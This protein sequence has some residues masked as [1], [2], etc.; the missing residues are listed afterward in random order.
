MASV[1]KITFDKTGTLTY[2]TPEVTAVKS[3]LSVYSE[4]EEI[5]A[6]CASAEQLSEHPLGKAVAR[7]YTKETKKAAEVP[8]DFQM[9]PGQGVSCTADSKAILAGNAKMMEQNNIPIPKHVQ[10]SFISRNFMQ[11][12][13]RK[14]S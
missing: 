6:L 5:Y 1:T 7:C 13:C 10:N 9:I 8:Q 2:G 3:V 14:I 12:V 11:I 4:E